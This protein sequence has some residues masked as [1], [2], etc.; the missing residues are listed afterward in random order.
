MNTEGSNGKWI[1]LAIAAFGAALILWSMSARAQTT[2]YPIEKSFY[3][4]DSVN[5]LI[6]SIA[7]NDSVLF[8]KLRGYAVEEYRTLREKK[9]KGVRYWRLE[10][11]LYSG[12]FAVYP[13]DFAVLD[14]V[15]FNVGHFQEVYIFKKE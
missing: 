14:V 5:H 6:G 13:Q 4:Q 15:V 11:P 7:V 9:I 10:H 1:T 8:I 2:Q 3:A 12:V